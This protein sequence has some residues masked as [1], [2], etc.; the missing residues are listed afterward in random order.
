MGQPHQNHSLERKCN[1]LGYSPDNCKWATRI[2]QQNNMDRNRCLTFKEHTLTVAQ[3]ARVIGIRPQ[4]I[5]QRLRRGWPIE[6]VLSGIVQKH[7]NGRTFLFNGG[8]VTLAQLSEET[9]IPYKLLHKRIVM[10]G[11][12]VGRAAT[13]KSG[14]RT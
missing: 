11:W 3:W 12:D 14:E 13:V 7:E 6:R 5:D 9:K 4:L 8:E 1:D 2:E 10:R